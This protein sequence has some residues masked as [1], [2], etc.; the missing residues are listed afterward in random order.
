MDC[1]IELYCG[2]V[3]EVMLFD[4]ETSGWS[5][6]FTFLYE[7]FGKDAEKYPEYENKPEKAYEDA[8]ENALPDN[9]IIYMETTEM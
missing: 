5:Y 3:E 9:E 7:K 1:I 2:I 6:Y 4:D 8:M